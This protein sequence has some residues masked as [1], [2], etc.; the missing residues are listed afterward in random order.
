[1][2]E[3]IRRAALRAAMKTAIIVSLSGCYD[4]HSRPTRVPIT[5][6]GRVERDAAVAV[7][8]DAPTAPDV[9]PLACDEHLA[10]LAI[11]NPTPP[12]DRWAWGAQFT[13]EATRLDPLTGAC[14]MELE[15]AADMGTLDPSVG[16]PL[17]MACCDV[18]VNTQ[19]LVSSSSLGC[20]PW[21]PPCPPEMS[22]EADAGD[23][24]A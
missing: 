7:V 22:D 3:R 4:M 9:P 18:V 17:R 19:N 21:G 8:V 1:M 23:A 16:S 6:A 10:M 20:T 5:D 12:D 11:T 13:D 14:C 2:D 15:V 24:I